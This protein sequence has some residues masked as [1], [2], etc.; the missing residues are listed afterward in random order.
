MPE[1]RHTHTSNTT[2]TSF[3]INERTIYWL[4]WLL[5]QYHC[6]WLNFRYSSW[7][8]LLS[9][10]EALR[11]KRGTRLFRR[12]TVWAK[13]ASRPTWRLHR[14]HTR[15]CVNRECRLTMLMIT[16]YSSNNS[17]SFS[18][19]GESWESYITRWHAKRS[20]IFKLLKIHFACFFVFCF[21]YILPHKYFIIILLS[22]QVCDIFHLNTQSKQFRWIF[23]LKILN[24]FEFFLS[25]HGITK[26]VRTNMNEY[27]DSFINCTRSWKI[28]LKWTACPK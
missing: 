13:S 10:K 5:Q 12:T 23:L 22:C 26:F 2:K 17:Y 14:I 1:L 28:G 16:V 24:G 8:N 15:P 27:Q 11:F 20:K 25:Q 7:T 6:K 4:G 3:A 18:V 19:F 9:I 21:Y